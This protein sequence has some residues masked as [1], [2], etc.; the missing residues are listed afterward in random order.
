LRD[1]EIISGSILEYRKKEYV[2]II[3]LTD[4]FCNTNTN[5]AAFSFSLA[6]SI[7]SFLFGYY[8]V[9]NTQITTDSESKYPP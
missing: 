9:S 5:I 4:V 7:S 1:E 3:H 6:F 2:M 8:D